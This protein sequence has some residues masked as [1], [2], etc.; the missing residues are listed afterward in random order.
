[1]SESKKIFREERL[2]MIYHA[3][4]EKQKVFV[5]DLAK[6]FNISESSVR[7]DLAELEERN[8]IQR[9]HGGAILRDEISNNDIVINLDSINERM[10]HFQLEKEA[11]GRKT[12]SLVEDGDTIMMDGGSTTLAVA[13]HLSVRKNLLV[14]TNTSTIGE[15]LVSNK[16]NRV[17]ITGGEL[18]EGTNTMVGPS[19]EHAI[20][21]YRTDKAIVGVSGILLEEGCFSA[22]PLEAEV[23]RLMILH[24]RET[25][26]VTD[27][28]KIGTRAFCFVCG[29][30]N[31]RT[32]VT[33][34]NLTKAARE[35]LERTG[36]EVILV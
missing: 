17:I 28:T 14:V 15:L 30:Q 9:T 20:E 6:E 29:F 5:I 27:S 4:Q 26:I 16:N 19:T 24:S 8:L 34:R 35:S 33:D 18:T 23:K 10:T 21:Q 3:I 12:A 2:A 32:L 13:R 7:L 36:I 1:M 31:V 11:I 22:V 25:I